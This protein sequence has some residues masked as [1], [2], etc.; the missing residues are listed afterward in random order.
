V[1]ACGVP[2]APRGSTTTRASLARRCS[3]RGSGRA[4]PCRSWSRGGSALRELAHGILPEALVR[5]GLCAGVESL[6]SHVLLPV[7]AEVLAGR[8]PEPVETSA[9]FVIAEALTNVIK[10]AGAD[11][12]RVRALATGDRLE[13][14]VFDDGRGGADPTGGSGLIGLADRVEAVGGSMSVNSPAGTGTTLSVS[15]P[16]GQP[17]LREQA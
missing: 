2:V 6:L 13:V 1:R 12:A 11:Q 17:E 8:L 4:C 9:Y 14:E 3:R 10:H 5:G 16:I 15:L 7:D